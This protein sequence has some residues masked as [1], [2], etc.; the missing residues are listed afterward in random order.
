MAGLLGEFYPADRESEYKPDHL[1]SFWW[2]E[3]RWGQC[4]QCGSIGVVHIGGS[5]HLRPCGHYQS[6]SWGKAVNAL[7][8]DTIWRRAGNDTQWQPESVGS[9]MRRLGR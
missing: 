7:F 1:A 3:G 2:D 4:Y 6:G 5:F 9:I 8:L